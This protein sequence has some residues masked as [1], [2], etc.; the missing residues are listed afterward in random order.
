MQTSNEV[1]RQRDCGEPLRPVGTATNELELLVGSDGSAS[2][3]EMRPELAFGCVD[4][5]MYEN[6]A[7]RITAP[8][9][10]ERRLARP[11]G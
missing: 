3:A 9:P 5:F 11:H 4:W 1:T 2:F 6:D 8:L 7:D 10:A